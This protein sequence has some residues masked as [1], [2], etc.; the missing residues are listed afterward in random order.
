MLFER[1]E[2]EEDIP[3]FCFTKKKH[4]LFTAAK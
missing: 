2:E 3:F 4:P 1:T